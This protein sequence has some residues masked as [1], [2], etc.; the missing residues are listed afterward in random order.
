VRALHVAAAIALL[1]AAGACIKIVHDHDC[2]GGTV[3]TTA[4]TT[5]GTT[6]GVIPPQ[7]FHAQALYVVNLS[8][9]AANLAGT[10]ADLI[11]QMNAALAARYLS[12]DEYAVLPIY[13]GV[14]NAP[15]L[16]YGDPSTTAGDLSASLGDATLS[17][18]YDT[19]LGSA[20]QQNLYT[21][22]RSLD[23]ATLPP[24]AEG[25]RSPTFFG[26]PLDL[27]LVVTLQSAKRLCADGDSA[28]LL[29]GQ[30]P[31]D[32]FSASDDSGNA[33]WLKLNGG[34]YPAARTYQL[35][36][37]TGE[38]QSFADLQARCSAMPGFP[39][40]LLDALQPSD[41]PYYGDLA[42]GLTMRGWHAESIDF[43]DAI[44]SG[45]AQKLRD[46]AGR[47]AAAAVH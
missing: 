2:D 32:A 28:C 30:S 46:V 11:T 16:I 7:V 39:K 10:Y 42:G 43:C 6:G 44:A 12:V 9:S 24:P 1:Y 33:A 36:I 38:Q 17:G 35:Y 22:T 41:V 14:N 31:L 23:Q 15:Q 47:I 19:P 27:F 25:G 34:S 45:G 26:P 20:E 8:R 18:L 13:G 40:T 21:I 4:G 3:G 29:V 5:V 37:M